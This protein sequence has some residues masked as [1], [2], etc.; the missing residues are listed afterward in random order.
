MIKGNDARKHKSDGLLPIKTQKLYSLWDMIQIF[1]RDII[2][3]LSDLEQKSQ[4]VKL[5]MDSEPALILEKDKKLFISKS[6]SRP[7]AVFE[8]LKLVE[9]KEEAELL[10]QMLNCARQNVSEIYTELHRIEIQFKVK[11]SNIGFVFIPDKKANYLRSAPPFQFGMSVF[12]TFPEA[13][14]EINEAANCLA[15]DLHTAAAFQL[16]RIVEC[17]LRNLARNMGVKRAKNV[18]LDYAGWMDVV[19]EIQARLEVKLPKVK[20]K[21]N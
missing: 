18:S 21:K 2:A 19:K 8:K 3:A 5:I 14:A 11:L 6:L 17:G 7:C 16:M 10:I 1:G 12:M 13:R 4:Y 15:A 9:L 20:G